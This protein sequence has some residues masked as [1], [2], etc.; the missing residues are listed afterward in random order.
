VEILAFQQQEER[1]LEFADVPGRVYAGDRFWIPPQRSRVLW[2]LS[3]RNPFFSYGEV[4]NFLVRE[5]GKPAG[6]A[7]A[8]INSKAA[9]EGRSVG[10]L[11]FFECLPDYGI[12]ERLLGEVREWLRGRGVQTVWGP[13]NFSTWNTYRLMTRG[14]GLPQFFLEP[15][16]PSYYPEYFERAGFRKAMAFYSNYV[17]DPEKHIRV[18]GDKLSALHASGY[19]LRTFDLRK[20]REE[21]T[22]IYQLSI[23]AFKDNWGYTEI[24]EGEFLQLYDGMENIIDPDLVFFLYDPGGKP[25]GFSFA[26]PEVSAAV[27]AMRGEASWLAKLRF[28][29]ARGKADTMMFKTMGILPEAR[30]AGLG[31]ALTARLHQVAIGKGY[32]KIIHALMR[33]DN[34]MR[35]ISNKGGEAFKEYA[36]YQ[37]T[38]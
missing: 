7:S 38:G 12:A 8:I 21:L 11:G 25:V 28:L 27:R 32:R 13:V 34:F 37:W 6:R 14:F 29:R 23:Q 5:E 36:V 24:T 17:S 1:L 18:D 19:T 15:Y 2:Q 10:Y 4:Q 26:L 3:P 22:L 30:G 35:K 16:N 9:Q 31:G 20:F 33:E